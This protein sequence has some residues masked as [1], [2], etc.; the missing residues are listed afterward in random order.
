MTLAQWKFSGRRDIT[1]FGG[2]DMKIKTTLSLISLFIIA[3]VAHAQAPSKAEEAAA[4]LRSLY[5]SQDFDGG[6]A[7]GQRQVARFPDAEETRAWLILHMSRNNMVKE[8]VETA[9]K[10]IASKPDSFWSLFAMAGALNRHEE[11]GSEALVAS[12]K[13]LALQPRHPDAIW[14]RAEALRRQNKKDEAI[15]FIEKNQGKLKNPAELIVTKALVLY[16][17]DGPKRDEAKVT[18]AFAAFEEAR[19]IDPQNL[20]ASYLHGLYLNASRRYAESHALLKKAVALAPSSVWTHWEY[21]NAIMGL[22]DRSEEQKQ[23]E[24]ESDINALLSIRG[25]SLVTL[26]RIADQYGRFKLA[27]KQ[28]ATEDRILELGPE[29]REAEWTLVNRYRRFRS[30]MKQGEAKDPAKVAAYRKM[31]RDFIARPRH[32][33]ERLKGDAYRELFYLVKDDSL[34]SADEILEVVNGMVKYEGLNPHTTYAEGAIAIA[35]RK[36]HFREA[37]KIARAGV[38]E[39]KKKID[40]QRR[41]YETEG[42]YEKGL[43]WMTSLMYD[44]LGWVFFNEGRLDEAEKELLRAYD[45][46]REGM[47]TLLHLGRVYEAKNDLEKAEEY[48]IKGSGIQTTGENPNAGALEKLYEKRKGSLEG[49]EQYL[50][51]IKDLDRAKRRE[52]ILQERVGEPQPAAAFDLKSISGTPVSLESLR[53]K[54]VVIN[55]WGVWC[56][57]CVEE[58]PE[59]Q[60]LHEKY[61]N[62]PDVVILTINNDPNPG[63][64]R[65]WMQKNKYGFAV[66]FDD[67]F[68]NKAG[69]TA[70]PTTW[71]LDRQ[72]RKAF[73]KVGWSEKLAE[74]FG[75]RIETL[76]GAQMN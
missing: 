57:W 61:K 60:K 31:L 53:G 72:G 3:V 1:P 44:A 28:N 43:N 69:I 34:T 58:M 68:V 52:R 26:A 42:D 10:M 59:F 35:E 14:M 23:A 5:F 47:S 75:W 50:A 39:A 25:D 8:A 6:Y 46:N 37:E 65:P 54:I 11:R 9:E 13:A 22:K 41:F 24:V 55:F 56:G 2:I 30:E 76:R 33:Q 67:G 45:L 19:R 4:R 48:Y 70:F 40:S 29:S 16:P 63:I 15:D 7:E 38:L 27:D 17:T 62:D 20:N 36:K 21:W 32:E 51:K 12:E 64:V 66:L 74:E 49:Y 18:A 71:F 73:V